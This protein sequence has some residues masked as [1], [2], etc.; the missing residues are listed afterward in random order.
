MR[1]LAFVFA[2]L[3]LAAC[4]PPQRTDGTGCARFVSR[5]VTWSGAAPDIITAR[6]DGPNCLQ[7]FVTLSIRSAAG[8]ALWI[9]A[10]TYYDMVAGGMPPSAAPNVSPEQ[11]DAFLSG[12]AEPT[13]GRT[14][15]LPQW[16]NG[17][18]TL[19]ESADIFAYDTPF[20]RETYEALRARNLPTLCYAAAVEA[21]H[22]LIVDPLS[23]APAMIV[24]YG[25]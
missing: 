13:L 9:H 4:G 18:A 10:G 7:T 11:M 17:A 24:A 5:E 2:V 8:E 1:T 16:R 3:T 21:T 20:D 23:G 6:A 14:S 19:T 15:T 22:C 12:W 25:P